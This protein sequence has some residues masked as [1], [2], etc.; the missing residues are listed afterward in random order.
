MGNLDKTLSKLNH[1]VQN[2]GQFGQITEKNWRFVQKENEF[3]KPQTATKR[4]ICPQ[5][6]CFK[7]KGHLKQL[8]KNGKAKRGR[9]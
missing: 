4:S 3:G 5:N 6:L 7:T 2:N 8:K 1:F 9:L